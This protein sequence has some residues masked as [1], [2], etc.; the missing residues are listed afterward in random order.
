MQDHVDQS[1]DQCLDF[2][3]DHGAPP[4]TML[5]VETGNERTP[6]REAQQ[7]KGTPSAYSHTGTPFAVRDTPAAGVMFLLHSD[8][9]HC[10]V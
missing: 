7:A 10:A 2:T 8:G 5:M 1:E 6:S 3:D 9:L 4:N